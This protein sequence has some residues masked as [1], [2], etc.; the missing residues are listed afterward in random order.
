MRILAVLL[1]SVLLVAAAASAQ[2]QCPLKQPKGQYSQS[3]PKAGLEWYS[4]YS[5]SQKAGNGNMFE[6]RVTNLGHTLLKYD[7]PVGRM[8]NFGLP[9][10]SLD[11]LCIEYGF[12][13][14]KRGDLK[15]GRGTEHTP[16]QVWEGEGEPKEKGI[17]GV[18]I[19]HFDEGGGD[20]EGVVILSSEQKGTV[21]RYKVTNASRVTLVM[22]SE[23]RLGLDL[24]QKSRLGSQPK[25]SKKGTVFSVNIEDDLR[26]EDQVTVLLKKKGV[27]LEPNET[28][29]VEVTS[30]KKTSVMDTRIYLGAGS[31][32]TLGVVTIP[33]LAPED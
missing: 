10:G 30:G 13:N 3:L 16:T 2:D 33:V 18:F 17:R 27:P 26:I 24:L 7:W 9:A 32:R 21:I 15:Y 14:M 29:S 12:P 4:A 11:A 5:P 6:R 25:V 19:F 28:R 8:A 20:P 22:A 23:N 31:G 1:N